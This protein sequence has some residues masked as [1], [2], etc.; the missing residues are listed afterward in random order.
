M[1]DFKYCFRADKQLQ[2]LLVLHD[3]TFSMKELAS[4]LS[5]IMTT[6]KHCTQDS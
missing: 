5:L 2:C 1:M 4:I 6:V 3:K